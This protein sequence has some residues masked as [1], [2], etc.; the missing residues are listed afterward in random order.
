MHF[1]T[2][3]L[4]PYFLAFLR[5]LLGGLLIF[6]S[7][8]KIPKPMLF[9]ETVKTYKLLPPY[10]VRPFGYG[11]PWIELILGILLLIGW[12]TKTVAV[13][14]GGLYA[15]F[16]IALII[17]FFRGR[18]ELNCGCFGTKKKHK[19]T[20]LLIVRDLGLTLA[21]SIVAAWGG[22]INSID[23]LSRTELDLLE[24]RLEVYILPIILIIL[25]LI[26]FA[27]LFVRSLRL[28]DLSTKE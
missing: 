8:H 18:R 24:N 4:T 5:Y 17:N 28:V 3:T 12:Q 14:N 20:C 15:A 9:V 19:L 11:L 21:A 7:L 25:G 13:I 10:A 2:L 16:T 27:R 23:T 22:G 26:V 6:A 1:K